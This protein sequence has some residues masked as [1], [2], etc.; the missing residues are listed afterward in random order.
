MATRRT[1]ILAYEPDY[2]VAPGGTLSETLDALGMSQAELARRTELTTKHISQIVT[3]DAAI[4]PS[5]A[6]R[7]ERATSVPSHFW[8]ALEA[9]YQAMQ[10]RLEDRARLISKVSWLKSFPVNE[11]RSRGLLRA[12]ASKV[13]WIEQLLTLFGVNSI[14]AWR[15]EWESP[16]AVFRRSRSASTHAGAIAVW[17]RLAELQ[18]RATETKAFDASKFRCALNA[19]R[20]LTQATPEVFA[21][22]L[23]SLC[24]E[25]GVAVVFEPELSGAP[26]CGAM[27]WLTSSKAMIA[28]SLRYKTND[29]FWFSFFHECCHVLKHSKSSGFVDMP[30]AGEDDER[31]AEANS[32]AANFLI[33]QATSAQ[34]RELRSR[35]AVVAFAKG[36]GIHP[37]IVVGRLQHERVLSRA[38]MNDVKVKLRWKV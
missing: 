17:L 8:S 1:S 31:E 25:H 26:V 20:P 34:L 32:W 4:S 29:Q 15:L 36:Q 37:G 9:N 38:M 10:R 21:P 12:D 18:A 30:G 13:E 7:L 35:S 24:A 16:Q 27:R 5:V 22:K 6:L 23:R 28:L 19:A 3:G 33:P 11:L 2:A 14:D